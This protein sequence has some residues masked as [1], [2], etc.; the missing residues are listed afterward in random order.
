M[1]T[2]IGHLLTRAN[3]VSEAQLARALEVQN[4][5]GGRI[6]TLLLERAILSEEDLGKALALQH[7][8]GYV[9][10]SVLADLPPETL[11]ALPGRFAL[12]HFA[13]PYERG[14]G[15]VKMALR[16]PGDLRIF[17]ELVFVT[18]HKVLVAVAPEVR[19]YQALEKY[20]GKLRAPRFA[21]LAEKLSRPQRTPSARPADPPPA[22]DFFAEMQLV[23][24]A[25]T[26]ARPITLAPSPDPE[27]FLPPEPERAPAE[28]PTPPR[29][30][31]FGW[32]PSPLAAGEAAAGD[33]PDTIP[34][35]D[36][37]S[38]R[39]KP[40]AAV[41]EEVLPPAPFEEMVPFEDVGFES[42]EPFAGAPE[43]GFP[44][45]AAATER[46]AIADAVLEALGRRFTRAAI[47][48]SRSD[49]VTGW[50]AA[51]DRVD[52]SGVRSFS[53]SWRE[54]SVFLN[55]RLSRTF[56][57]GPLPSLPRHDRLAAALG[58]WPGE[59]V[60]QPVFIGE[61]PVAFLL[62]TA[63]RP[64]AV[65]AEDLGYLRE[66]SEAASSAF[67]NAIRLKKREI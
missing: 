42:I 62:V 30:S 14:E 51:G 52:P 40:S 16:D 54:P 6:G 37:T 36:T 55:A 64:G 38:S 33:G 53:A 11:A 43:E 49:G 17:D 60:V 29:P 3:L 57:L 34:W 45:V 50:V 48:S 28:A 22:P 25:E 35:E 32:A 9:S 20:Y 23:E 1:K 10:W 31:P 4:F 13:V 65:T 12:K 8:C 67:E 41:S 66:L 47:F 19:I 61:R 2:R 46:D 18:G 56:Y 5:A 63:P 27:L 59:C 58:G 7:G 21:L 26:D 15:Y 39:S 24:E 44:G